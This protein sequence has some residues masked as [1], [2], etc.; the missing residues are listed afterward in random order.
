VPPNQFMPLLMVT[1]SAIGWAIAT[2]A[3]L[4]YLGLGVQVSNADW[5]LDLS[6]SVSY[7]TADWWMVFPGIMIILVILAVNLI[8]DGMQTGLDPTL[9]YRT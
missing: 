2:G 6:L 3:A 7:V 8:G 9:R 1:T 5:G 4:N